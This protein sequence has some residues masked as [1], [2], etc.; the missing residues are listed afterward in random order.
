M[1]VLFLN[2][3]TDFLEKW[4]GDTTQM[5]KTAKY[6]KD[7]GVEVTLSSQET[8]DTRGYDLLHVFNIQTS[9]AGVRQV[10]GAKHQGTPVVLSPI[11]WDLRNIDY[12][13]ARV[14]PYGERM[15]TSVL[16]HIHWALPV[17][18]RRI[19]RFLRSRRNRCWSREMLLEA[20]LL[21]PNSYAEL[22]ILALLFDAPCLRS[23]AM[24]VP[25]GADPQEGSISSI[26]DTNDIVKG[27]PKEYVLEVGRIEPVKGQSTVIRAL[28]REKD[29]PLV[30]IGRGLDTMY[31]RY[32]LELG[33]ARGNT[34]FL[35][36][37]ANE[38]LPAFYRRAKVHVLPSLRESP[39]LATLEAALYGA[40]CVV[41]FYGPVNEYF[42][43]DVWYCDPVDPTSV[44]AAVLQ[45]WELPR[46]Y[47]KLQ[48]KV[49]AEFTWE[50]AARRTLSAY[51]K[52]LATSG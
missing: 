28:S 2:S 12:L 46:G 26:T 43:S 10:R 30:F 48:E 1:K 47:K 11:Y 14:Y 41:S 40:N 50:I 34:F 35:G 16:G 52:L 17:V 15:L 37:I 51:E 29:I 36:E 21:L 9:K 49:Q 25:N 18:T 20:D 39:G 13:A 24:V 19:G 45:A 44:R 23:K 22:E 8:P 3:R 38:L 42:G 5:V 32:C 7:A 27:I 4:G 31:G 6:L 33:K